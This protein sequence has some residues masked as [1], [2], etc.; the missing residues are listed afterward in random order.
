MKHIT[1]HQN[2]K[3]WRAGE[4]AGVSAS[5][6]TSTHTSYNQSSLQ[7]IT[8]TVTLVIATEMYVT[9]PCMNKQMWKEASKVK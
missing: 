2:K 1:V 6:L 4:W 3:L 7:A 5:L 9:R 8:G